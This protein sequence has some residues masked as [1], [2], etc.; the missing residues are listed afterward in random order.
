MPCPLPRCSS[1]GLTSLP[2]WVQVNRVLGYTLHQGP[3]LR[4]QWLGFMSCTQH[5]LNTVSMASW[6]FPIGLK[7][8]P[9]H[10]RETEAVNPAHVQAQYRQPVAPESLKFCLSPGL[11]GVRVGKAVRSWPS[12]GLRAPAAL[13]WDS[14]LAN[15]RDA[16]EVETAVCFSGVAGKSPWACW[17]L[18]KPL[19][20]ASPA[21]ALPYIPVFR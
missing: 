8:L 21:P 4:P 5:W 13:G 7:G 16:R 9:E 10:S 11:D 2:L 3:I 15:A 12:P 18:L 1:P 17:P 20:P 14:G 19:F 6:W